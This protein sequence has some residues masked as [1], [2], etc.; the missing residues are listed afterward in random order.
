MITREVIEN[1][2]ASWVYVT[3]FIEEF[4]DN[5]TSLPWK[6]FVRAV[7]QASIDAGWN[8]YFRVG[9]SVMHIIFSTC[10]RN[11]LENFTPAPPRVTLGKDINREMFIALS[12]SNIWFNEPERK[13]FV[14]PK[15]AFSVLRTYLADLWRETRPAEPL[16]LVANSS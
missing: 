6:V 12:Y 5:D 8:E 4:P 16:P 2:K 9:T 10:E 3:R 13:D 14:T 15:T 1:N 7:I 11:G